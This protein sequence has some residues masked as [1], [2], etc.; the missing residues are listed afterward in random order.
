MADTY[1]NR[2]LNQMQWGID[3]ARAHNLDAAIAHLRQARVYAIT[4]IGMDDPTAKRL[5]TT[6][7]ETLQ[8]LGVSE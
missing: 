7:E 1:F 8:K 6:I 3:E 2:A 4:S 5:L